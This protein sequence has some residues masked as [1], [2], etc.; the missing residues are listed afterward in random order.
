M[1]IPA[2]RQRLAVLLDEL[3]LDERFSAVPLLDV[4]PSHSFWGG[5]I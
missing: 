2:Q 1:C 3:A 5:H 4:R